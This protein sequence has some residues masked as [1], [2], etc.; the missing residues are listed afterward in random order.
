MFRREDIPFTAL[1]NEW[2]N[3]RWFVKDRDPAFLPVA[4]NLIVH[5][6]QSIQ[7]QNSIENLINIVNRDDLEISLRL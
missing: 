6:I 3:G 2:L 4:T 7:V 1:L 5:A